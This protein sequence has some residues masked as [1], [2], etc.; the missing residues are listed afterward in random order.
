MENKYAQMA[1]LAAEQV[2]MAQQQLEEAEARQAEQ[3]RLS[4]LHEALSVEMRKHS[5]AMNLVLG[6]RQVLMTGARADALSA[7][8]EFRKEMNEIAGQYGCKIVPVG[9]KTAATVVLI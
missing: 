5:A 2:L 1:E 7:F 8:V 6:L 3:E 9:D 4:A